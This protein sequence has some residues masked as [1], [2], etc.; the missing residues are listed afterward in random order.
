MMKKQR[1]NGASFSCYFV[2]ERISNIDKVSLA[3][4]EQ[5]VLF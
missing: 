4:E 3:D 1:E 5:D 2:V